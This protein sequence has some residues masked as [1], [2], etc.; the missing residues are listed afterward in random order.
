MPH[1]VNHVPRPAAHGPLPIAPRLPLPPDQFHHPLA[2]QPGQRPFDA[3]PFQVHVERLQVGGAGDDAEH[4]QR[5][6]HGQRRHR[7]P[8]IQVAHHRRLR[9]EAEKIVV[10]GVVEKFPG[11]RGQPR[12]VQVQADAQVGVLRAGVV[13]A[14]PVVYQRLAGK[15]QVEEFAAKTLHGLLFGR[16]RLAPPPAGTQQRDLQILE[17]VLQLEVAPRPAH[18]VRGL[19]GRGAAQAHA[20]FARVG[21]DDIDVKIVV[22]RRDRTGWLPCEQQETGEDWLVERYSALDYSTGCVQKAGARSDMTPGT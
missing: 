10:R 7:L 12:V 22:H 17:A 18:R 6:A 11:Q 5:C 14:A 20:I 2:R 4:A 13:G 3:L 21:A 8:H 19:A 9:R 1:E 16:Q 15:E